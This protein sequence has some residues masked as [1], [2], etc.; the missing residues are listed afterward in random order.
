MATTEI[1]ANLDMAERHFTSWT[2]YDLC[3]VLPHRGRDYNATTPWDYDTVLDVLKVYSRPY[4]QAIAGTPTR[5]ANE[6]TTSADGAMNGTRF[7]LEYDIGTPPA[8]CP[9]CSCKKPTLWP[10]SG[11]EAS[12]GAKCGDACCCVAGAGRC[13]KSPPTPR[14]VITAPTEI[15]V[16]SLWYPNGYAVQL[17]SGLSWAPAPGRE[18]VIAVYLNTTVEEAIPRKATVTILAR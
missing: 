13:G 10:L 3:S 14:P 5:M 7:I 15:A 16:P 4:A 2:M 12:C 6:W 17:S 1:N 8:A 9:V 18:N 11:C